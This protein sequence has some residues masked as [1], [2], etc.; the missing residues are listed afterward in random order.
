[1][2]NKLNRNHRK[3][4]L[5]SLL[6]QSSLVNHWRAYVNSYIEIDDIEELVFQ[7]LKDA[8]IRSLQCIFR[9]NPPSIIS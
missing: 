4:D 1:M 9:L 6:I 5:I 2:E 7:L 3:N 8:E